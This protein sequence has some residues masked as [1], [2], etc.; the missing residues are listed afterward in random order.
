MRRRTSPS[1]W[2]GPLGRRDPVIAALLV[3]LGS[4]PVAVVADELI[5]RVGVGAVGVG[6]IEVAIP[7][8]V[9]GRVHCRLGALSGAITEGCVPALFVGVAASQAEEEEST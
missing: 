6:G 3:L 7:V 9:E 5:R 8:G 1:A 2:I 4:L